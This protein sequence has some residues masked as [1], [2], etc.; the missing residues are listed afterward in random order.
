[1]PLLLSISKALSISSGRWS[2]MLARKICPVSLDISKNPLAENLPKNAISLTEMN[3]FSTNIAAEAEVHYSFW[4]VT[5]IIS[6]RPNFTEQ[7]NF[8]DKIELIK[9]GFT[10]IS[11]TENRKTGKSAVML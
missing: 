5:G 1:M 3:S 9:A 7:E 6:P 8:L 11:P 10:R 2:T 4:R